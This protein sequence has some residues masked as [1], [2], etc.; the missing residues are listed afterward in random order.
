MVYRILCLLT[1]SL[2]FG[3]A[4]ETAAPAPDA[5][6]TEPPE[7]P[8]GCVA[9]AQA[10]TPLALAERLSSP[11][12]DPCDGEAR[13]AY[14]A[15]TGSTTLPFAPALAP[16]EAGC[17][18]GRPGACWLAGW[19]HG[20]GLL[21]QADPAAWATAME[22]S[23]SLGWLR[24]CASLEQQ[25]T[26]RQHEAAELRWRERACDEGK[27]VADACLRLLTWQTLAPDRRQ[28]VIDQLLATLER[29]CTAGEAEPCRTLA[30]VLATGRMGFPHDPVR[31]RALIEAGCTQGESAMCVRLGRLVEVEGE[32][33]A[34]S[35]AHQRNLQLD[36][37]ACLLRGERCS[38]YFHNSRNLGP[39]DGAAYEE[40]VRAQERLC[41]Q[42][43]A[44]ACRALAT[45]AI[46]AEQG[47]AQ[48]YGA[49]ALALREAGCA[50]HRKGDCSALITLHQQ[51]KPGVSMSG[52]T[53][54]PT[55]RAD[56]RSRTCRLGDHKSCAL[57][58]AA[59]QRFG[60]DVLGS[61][62]AC[63]AL[64]DGL[65][66]PS[67]EDAALRRKACAQLHEA[68]CRRLITEAEAAGQPTDALLVDLR[69]A[70]KNRPSSACRAQFPDLHSIPE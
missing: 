63:A 44:S 62:W 1:F 61:G 15:L 46:L 18:A 23:C 40:R 52:G 50:A 28:A 67:A 4:S 56:A 68:A 58:N 21:G 31:S 29:A 35:A 64:A 60:C 5:E 17:A 59:D 27:G 12:A 20:Q 11:D 41:A 34:A 24:A 37:D 69:R 2:F 25:A 16:A 19:I 14:Y 47:E 32:T 57:S 49:K 54:N 13:A 51:L 39:G 38:V 65:E 53:P 33:A 42:D 30:D 45:T 7:T 43:Q 70:C 55:A 26:A 48:A 66:T 36:K 22:R 10:P 6:V 8:V 3:C 9:V